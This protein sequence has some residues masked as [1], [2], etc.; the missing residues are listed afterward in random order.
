MY[1][2]NSTACSGGH[3]GAGDSVLLC[4]PPAEV[5]HSGSL[6]IRGLNAERRK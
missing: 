3:T 6:K 5:P 4:T 1:L 2:E